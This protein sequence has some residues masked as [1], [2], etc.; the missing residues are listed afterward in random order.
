MVGHTH[1]DYLS[2]VN[3][4]AAFTSAYEY[5]NVSEIREFCEA[6]DLFDVPG[7]CFRK[8]RLSYLDERLDS[9]CDWNRFVQLVKGVDCLFLIDDRIYLNPIMRDYGHELN[10]RYVSKLQ[11]DNVPA[12]IA[13]DFSILHRCG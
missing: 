5:V 9:L 8:V 2:D 1:Q 11:Q 10:R 7:K 4:D 13:M 6:P 3:V 12:K